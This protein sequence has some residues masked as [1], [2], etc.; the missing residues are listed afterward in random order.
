[1]VFT[2]AARL[3]AGGRSPY[4]RDT[5]RYTPMLAWALVPSVLRWPRGHPLWGKLLFSA[6]DLVVGYLI[7]QVLVTGGSVASAKRG[8]E[9]AS[10]WLLNPVVINISTRGSADCIISMLVLL[11]L[12]LVMRRQPVLGGIVHGLAIHFKIYPV[13]YSL[14]Y[15]VSF[16]PA[17]RKGEAAMSR[18]YGEGPPRS[19]CW[20]RCLTLR[21]GAS[22]HGL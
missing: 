10:I 20:V 19:C 7:E 21:L 22:A 8:I 2:D 3:V 4:E 16:A 15:L 6:C 11:T 13:I 18:R 12:L 14:T 5:Y 9:W 17:V 1:M